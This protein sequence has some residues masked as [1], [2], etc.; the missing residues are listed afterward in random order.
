MSVPPH[1]LTLTAATTVVAASALA[2]PFLPRRVVN[3]W[4]AVVS[5]V[6]IL[7]VEFFWLGMFR[8]MVNNRSLSSGERAYWLRVFLLLNVFGAVLYWNRYHSP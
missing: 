5:A 2:F 4:A 1:I 3:P 6:P 7:L 8:H